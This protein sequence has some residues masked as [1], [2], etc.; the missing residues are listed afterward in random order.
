MC[1]KGSLTL[2]T[3]SF[4]CSVF[5]TSVGNKL[6]LDKLSYLQL[7][8]YTAYTANEAFSAALDRTKLN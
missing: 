4:V 2:L 3:L 6:H 5:L 7:T 8:A 1:K